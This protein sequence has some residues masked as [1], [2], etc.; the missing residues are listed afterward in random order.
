MRLSHR[1]VDRRH[2][3]GLCYSGSALNSH[4]ISVV[5]SRGYAPGSNSPSGSTGTNG[6]PTGL[7]LALS[8]D[9]TV[10]LAATT[11]PD[12]NDTITSFRVDPGMS[13]TPLSQLAITS[14]GHGLSSMQFDSTGA[15]LA[16]SSV[17]KVSIYRVSNGQ[18]ALAASI[19]VA[20]V[21]AVAWTTPPTVRLSSMTQL[22]S[23]CDTSAARAV[24]GSTASNSTTTTSSSDATQ[25]VASSVSALLALGLYVA[26]AL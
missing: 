20:G 16:V 3:A 17:S 10:L 4:Q 6:A 14:V 25:S 15:W 8:P 13:Q 1:A 9:D 5:S 12:G 18:L 11:V 22:A 23:A 26:L 2:A 24:G 19:D 7:T 21:R